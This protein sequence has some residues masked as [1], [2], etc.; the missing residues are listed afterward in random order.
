MNKKELNETEIRTRYITPAIQKS[1]WPLEQM[2]EEYT[3]YTDGRIKL[4]PKRKPSRGDRKRIDYLL[5]HNSIPIAIVEAKDNKH[6]AGAGM[7]Q[8]LRYAE[9]LD[10]PFVYTSNGDGFIEHDKTR[11]SDIERELSLNEFPSPAELWNRYTRD[12]SL[13]ESQA[14][15]VSQPFFS[16]RDV[17]APRYYQRIAVQRTITAVAQGER[18]VLLVMATGTGKTYTA[19]QIIWRLRQAKQIRRVLFLVDRNI[20]AD[21]TMQGDFKHFGQDIMHKIKNRNAEKSYQVYFALYQSISGTEEESNIYKQFSPDF[22]DLIVIDECHRGSAAEDSAWR[23]ILTYFSNAIHLGLTATPKETDSVS[24]IDYFGEPIYTYSLKQGID[25]GFLAPFKVLRVDVD[26]DVDGWIPAAGQK[27][28]FGSVIEAREYGKKDWDRTIV[29]EERNK[30]V[31]QR[32]AEYL[33]TLPPYAKTIV[34]CVDIAH[35]ERMRRHLVNAIGGE[36]AT[37]RRYVVRITGDNPEGKAQLDHFIDPLSN[38]PVIATTSKLMTT[39]VDAKMC[40][41]IVLDTVIGSM[42]EFKQI[43]GRGTRL[44][45][46]EGKTDFTILDFRG[47]TQLFK[48]PDFDGP[49]I[50]DEEFPKPPSDLPPDGGG[51]EGDD[52]PDEPPVE[53]PIKYYVERE[54]VHILAERVQYYDA[55]GALI[56]KSYIDFSRENMRREYDSL[57]LFLQRWGKTGRKQAILNEL[58]EKGVMLA[59]LQELL[60]DDYDP[61][62]LI[63]HIAYERPPL[64][65]SERARKVKQEDV[66]TRYG[67]QAR[68]VLDALL[69]KYA[70]E[71]VTVLEQARNRKQVRQMLQINPFN[72][73][74]TPRELVNGFGNLDQYLQAV[75]QVTRHLYQVQ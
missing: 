1:G 25:D 6:E 58:S 31:A 70:D 64:T 41:V 36:A 50:Q 39:G 23:E 19:F 72:Q 62:D 44:R 16:G 37:E 21:Q 63:C 34:F 27:D 3:Y 28:K 24:N 38:Y 53:K 40:K 75:D 65:R 61:F 42:T 9:D 35:A 14:Q 2:R 11:T 8:A 10:V 57:D 43:I 33:A 13:D 45:V 7:D 74:G 56:T 4:H 55:S 48:D 5:Y 73:M 20:L 29:L 52:P 46:E 15:I 22:F 68:Q 17:F 71:G 66:Y 59:E 49:P 60:G 26:K 12:K 54:P 47:A 69:A 18:R 32:I 67:P 51:D 30:L